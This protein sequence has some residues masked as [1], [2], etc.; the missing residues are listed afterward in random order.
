MR[1]HVGS[2]GSRGAA[3]NAG[4]RPPGRAGQPEPGAV[5]PTPNDV[6]ERM[7]TLAG[8]TADDVVY[9]LGCGDGRIVIAAA[10]GLRRAWRRRGHRPAAHRRGERE[11]GAGPAC[12]TWSNSSRGDAMQTDVSDA[13]VVTLYLLSSSNARFETDPDAPASTRRPDRLARLQHGR[14]GP[15]RGGSFR[16]RPRKYAYTLLVAA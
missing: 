3:G 13:T 14:L 8:V 11:R 4:D 2:A 10:P 1:V 12:S 6:V 7:L 16:G 15:G 5:V 9:D